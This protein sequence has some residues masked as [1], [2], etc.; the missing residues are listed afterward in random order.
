MPELPE[1]ETIKRKLKPSIIGK[2]ISEINILSPK[3]FIGN[4]NDVL[5]RKII[6]VERYGK[7]LAIKSTGIARNASTIY[8]N[9]HFKL[10]GQILF[11]KDVDNATF[12]NTI[13]F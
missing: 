13:P 1:V 3:N 4:V 12:K 2:T 11:A 8:L 9:I 7:V 10:S 5:N 6:S